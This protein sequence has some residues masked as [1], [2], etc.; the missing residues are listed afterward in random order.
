MIL[1][2][3]S[4]SPEFLMLIADAFAPGPHGQSQI[5]YPKAKDEW[6]SEDY[7]EFLICKGPDFEAEWDEST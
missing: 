6:M 5:Q 1:L 3:K 2:V 7:S 4:F